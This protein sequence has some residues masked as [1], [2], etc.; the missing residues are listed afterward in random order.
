MIYVRAWFVKG[1]ENVSVVTYVATRRWCSL[2]SWHM[3]MSHFSLYCWSND[4]FIGCKNLK[5]S[6]AGVCGNRPKFSL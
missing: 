5:A 3:C 4:S 2:I 1:K 6:Q